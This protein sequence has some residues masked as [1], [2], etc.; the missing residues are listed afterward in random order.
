MSTFQDQNKII[1]KLRGKVF[2]DLSICGDGLWVEFKDGSKLMLVKRDPVI[3][4]DWKLL[5]DAQ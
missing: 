1:H 2:D 4:Y 5:E 3:R